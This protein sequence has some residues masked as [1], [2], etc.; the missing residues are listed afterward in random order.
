MNAPRLVEWDR[1]E[2][3]LRG[4]RVLAEARRN[5]AAK[6]VPV[7]L[8][9]IDFR[10]GMAVVEGTLRK[11][12]T[13]PFR[14]FLERIEAEG[15]TLRI[16]IHRPTA[17]G[18]IPVPGFFFKLA[19]GFAQADGVTVDAAA[20]AIVVSLDRFLPSF[21]DVEINEVGLVAGGVRVTL[22]AGGADLPRGE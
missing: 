17:L 4:E 11:G 8:D 20:K 6:G 12:M 14:F 22:G 16:P 13:I 2:L 21:L 7:E 3:K 10:E 1:L 5:L 19:E 15:R 9:R 18:F